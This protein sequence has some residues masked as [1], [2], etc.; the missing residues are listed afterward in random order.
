VIALSLQ[1]AN[2]TAA[3]AAA[4]A[5]VHVESTAVNITIPIKLTTVSVFT[6][7]NA[8]C[9]KEWQV[10]LVSMYNDEKQKAAAAEGLK[11]NFTTEITNCTE[12]SAA[13]L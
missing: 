4:A 11:L 1:N 3:A 8:T 12:V 5:D 10:A 7:V 9:A 13:V 2:S 6:L